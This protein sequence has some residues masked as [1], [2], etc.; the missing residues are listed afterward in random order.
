MLRFFRNMPIRRKVTLVILLTCVTALTAAGVALFA[1]QAFAFRQEFTA[2]LR[3]IAEIIKSNSTAAV[4]FKD[5]ATAVEILSSLKTRAAVEYA[6]INLPDGS[7]FASYEPQP[8]K[9][10]G[11]NMLAEEGVRFQNNEVLLT[12]RIVLDGELI[13]LLH[14]HA[15]YTR[16]LRQLLV[17]YG[18]ILIAV[19]TMAIF[20]AFVLSGRL[21][22]SISDPILGLAETA[23]AVSREHDYSVR[24]ERFGDDEIGMFTDAFNQMLKQIESQSAALAEGRE[25][26][27]A[28]VE[29]RTAMLQKTNAELT[30]ATEEAAAANRAKSEF[31]SRMSHELRTPM[32]AILGFGQLLQMRRDLNPK[33]T[34]SVNHILNAGRHLLVLID[35]VL[36]ISRIESGTMSLSLEAVLVR[37]LTQEVI[38]LLQPLAAKSEVTLVQRISEHDQ[39]CVFADRQRLKQT[40]LNLVSNAIKYNSNGGKVTVSGVTL[41]PAAN[42][43]D[44]A[45]KDASA[46]LFRISVADTGLGIAPEKLKRLFTPFDRLDAETTNVEGTG[47]GLALSKKMTEL[48]GGTLGVESTLGQ[49]SVF[50]IDLASAECPVKALGLSD[51]LQLNVVLTTSTQTVVYIEDNLSNLNLIRA[52]LNLRTGIKLFTAMQGSLGIDLVRDHSPDLVLLD[53]NLPDLSGHEVLARLRGDP[54]TTAIPILMLT[55]DATPGQ[56]E[57]LLAAGAT[58]FL[59]KPIDIPAFLK[60]VDELL[61]QNAS[62]ASKTGSASESTLAKHNGFP[63]TVTGQSDTATGSLIR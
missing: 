3:N 56:K 52:I 36:D 34:S 2:N 59:T 42:G 45:P 58:N 17:I 30:I 53:L 14:I 46:N 21:R 29:E 11:T 49:G 60:I 24:A 61:G 1:V 16:E 31:L 8:H 40:L 62:G 33:Q 57:R 4:T 48:M 37:P 12:E 10:T 9:D 6:S 26:L 54:K 35:E 20:L 15:D 27:E 5:R 51:A 50:W 39:A 47:L 41:P 63:A 28:R 38:D 13:G 25:L 23:R 55:A 44:E 19:L 18:V 43:A 32:N 22:H 7:I